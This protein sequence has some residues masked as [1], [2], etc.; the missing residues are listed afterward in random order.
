MVILYKDP[1]APP[2]DARYLVR[3]S[4]AAPGVLLG[5]SEEPWAEASAIDWGPHPYRTRFRAL[6]N[7]A[8]VAV[9]FDAA[10]DGPWYTMKDRDDS[11]WEEEVVEIFLDPARTGRDYAEV[12]IS[13]ANVVCDL[14]IAEGWP[15][16]RG[17]RDWHWEGLESRVRPGAQT[18]VPASGSW[19]ATAWMPWSGLR[20]LSADAA[21]AAPPHAGDSWRFNVFRIKRPGGPGRPEEGAVYAAWSVPEGPSF[22]APTAFR[23]FVFS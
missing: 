9:R 21:R 19:T 10:D 17:D 11:I 4:A 20:T 18:R 12:E 14:R 16:L 8:G 23:D 7:R 22:H 3:R 5:G 15:A 2:H 13:P 1:H 6:W